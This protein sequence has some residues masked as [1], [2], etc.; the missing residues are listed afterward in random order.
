MSPSLT[1]VVGALIGVA[2]SIA[3]AMLQH[4]TALRV[5]QE[6]D[7]RRPPRCTSVTLYA[8]IV[9]WEHASS[10]Q[11]AG[12]VA[13]ASRSPKLPVEVGV[14]DEAVY[15]NIALYDKPTTGHEYL[16][17]GS[18]VID[19]LCLYPWRSKLRFSDAGA[20]KDPHQLRQ[21]FGDQSSN[22]YV[23][24]VHAYNGLQEGN[25][26]FG[27]RMPHDVDEGRLVVDLSSVPHVIDAMTERPTA[28]LRPASGEPA[29]LSVVSYRRG[30]YVIE[31]KNLRKDDVLFLDL[32]LGESLHVPGDTQ[33]PQSEASCPTSEPGS[34]ATVPYSKRAPAA[35]TS[36]ATPRQSRSA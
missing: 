36:P 31:G 28:Q 33:R 16:F 14:H 11:A 4:R 30:I 2:G 32:T 9:R 34:S 3:V 13:D 19:M 25:E 5:S 26:D 22:A 8:K 18:G 24:V 21:T 15:T 27:L 20:E 1:A 35:E 6:S 23:V 12:Y 17:R 29:E 10:G 7:D